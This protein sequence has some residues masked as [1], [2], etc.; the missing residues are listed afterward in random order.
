MCAAA[1]ASTSYSSVRMPDAM[2]CSN[3]RCGTNRYSHFPYHVL[4]IFSHTRIA[5]PLA[6]A[7]CFGESHALSPQASEL[8]LGIVLIRD[9]RT[10]RSWKVSELPV[11]FLQQWASIVERKLKIPRTK[12]IADELSYRVATIGFVKANINSDV[13]SEQNLLGLS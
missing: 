1:S 8:T 3:A 13:N 11:V 2:A 9:L 4:F 12:K 7:S 5:L 6:S 10:P